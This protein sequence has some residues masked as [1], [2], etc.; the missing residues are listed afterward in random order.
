[1]RGRNSKIKRCKITR[2]ERD[3]IETKARKA[4]LITAHARKGINTLLADQSTHLYM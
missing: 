1:M 2:V 4:N 3:R